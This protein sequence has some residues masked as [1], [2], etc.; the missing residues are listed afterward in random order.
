MK[1][2]DFNL[3]LTIGKGDNEKE[4]V[5][6]FPTLG[7]V[8]DY[9]SKMSKVKQSEALDEMVKFLDNCG[10]PGKAVKQMSMPQINQV[11][12]ALVGGEQGK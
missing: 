6:E 9:Q 12:T 10:L 5:V 2:T 11:F 1:L 4:Y 8:E 7:Q 3:K